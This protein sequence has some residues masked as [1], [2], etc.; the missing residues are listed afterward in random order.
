MGLFFFLSNDHHDIMVSWQE[1]CSV[2]VLVI[3]THATTF[4][5]YS[6]DMDKNGGDD[7]MTPHTNTYDKDA[8]NMHHANKHEPTDTRRREWQQET[9]KNCKVLTQIVW[10]GS[11]HVQTEGKEESHVINQG[12]Y[13][14]AHVVTVMEKGFCHVG[15][16][17]MGNY[18]VA[19]WY[20][21]NNTGVI[22][23]KCICSKKMQCQHMCKSEMER[24]NGSLAVL[25]H[26]DGDAF[27]CK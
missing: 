3:W 7:T 24:K 25:Q 15:I 26:D 27:F 1:H 9:W 10:Y 8:W 19:I 14:A 6:L 2:V 17:F 20:A 16:L 13:T 18:S 21:G 23:R 5:A 11:H 12:S 4:N 22:K